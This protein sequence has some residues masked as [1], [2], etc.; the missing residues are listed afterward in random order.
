MWDECKNKRIGP[1]GAIYR[2]TKG[3]Q[4]SP[5]CKVQDGKRMAKRE[6]IPRISGRSRWQGVMGR[7][8]KCEGGRKRDVARETQEARRDAGAAATYTD[9]AASSKRDAAVIRDVVT[10]SKK[11]GV[12]MGADI[13]ATDGRQREGA[14]TSVIEF[15]YGRAK[16][17]VTAEKEGQLPP[18]PPASQGP[19]DTGNQ[20]KP[21]DRICSRGEVLLHI[22]GDRK[23]LTSDVGCCVVLLI[24]T[25]NNLDILTSKTRKLRVIV[26][27]IDIGT[28][29]IV[30]GLTH[31][32]MYSQH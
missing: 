1:R 28:S 22:E 3:V 16:E 2:K 15:V 19:E 9:A 7:H 17:W 6:Q 32:G 13:T 20:N 4:T 26:L 30:Q 5:I 24:D 21:R 29:K 25:D 14:G 23:D 8:V 31:I 27:G 18:P 10:V 12:R 11:D